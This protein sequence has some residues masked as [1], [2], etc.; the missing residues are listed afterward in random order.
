MCNR[1]ADVESKSVPLSYV[2]I[3]AW[4]RSRRGNGF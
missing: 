2:D 1:C 3:A 4:Q